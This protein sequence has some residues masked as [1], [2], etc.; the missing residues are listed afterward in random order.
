M[1]KKDYYAVLGVQKSATEDEIKSAYR[2]MAKQYHPDL[3]PNDAAAA[4]KF[5]ECNEAYSIIG[6]ADKRGKYDRGELDN[7][8]FNPFG[9]G[10]S[11]FSAGGFDDI[12]DIFSNF[13]GGGGTGRRQSASRGADISYSLNLTFMEAALGCTKTVTFARAEKC[14][15]CGGTG[16][17]DRNSYTTCDR[18]GGSGKVTYTQNTIFGQQVS[19]GVCDRCGGRGKIITNPCKDCNGRGVVQKKKVLNV[20]IPAGVENGS[21]LTLNGEGNASRNEGGMNGNL[22]LV[23]AVEKSTVFAREGLNLIADVPV[24]YSIAVSGGDI[25]IPTLNGMVVQKIPEGTTNGET[26]RFRGKGIK[27]RNGVGDLFVTVT[28][29]V[30]KNLTRAQKTTLDSLEKELT[31]K[32]Y[33]KRKVFLDEVDKLYRK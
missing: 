15:S 8:G 7:D 3:H 24:P 18:C 26:F 21:V 29:E 23:V 6:D 4:E 31:L 25:E 20:T 28:V 9:G 33:A 19:Y 5:K 17:K 10:A 22:L 14:D 16:A 32:N 13:M 11:G 2:K 1:A 27:A 12:F 30:P